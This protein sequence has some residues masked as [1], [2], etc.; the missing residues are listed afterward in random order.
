LQD[1]S[2]GFTFIQHMSTRID[3]GKVF[4][5][6]PAFNENEVITSVIKDL[7]PLNY[8]II[9]V[10]DGSEM[11]LQT[12]L[13]NFPV[14]VLRHKVNLGQGAA[15]QT[16]IEYALLKNSQN[17]VTF[18]AD[19]QHSADDIK[20]L[21]LLLENNEADICLG[22]RFIKGA[23]HNMS[24]TRKILIHSARLLNFCLTGIMLTDAH[25][26][27]RAMNR[28][29]ASVIQ[30]REN[31]MAH[32]TEL[33]TQIKKNKFRYKEVPV[34]IHYSAYS[35]KKGQTIWSSFRIFFDLLLNKIFK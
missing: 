13:S 9:V 19:G 8:Q 5:I 24:F 35:R 28:N 21:L 16:G 27:L 3:P 23:K 15:I 32:A 6:I 34:H 10:D 2:G 29:V 22:S 12:L 33:L 26:G 17:I 25:N 7:L 18:D 11:P 20:K 4:V 31:G 1:P 14:S 30:I